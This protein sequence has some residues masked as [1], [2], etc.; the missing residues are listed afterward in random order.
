[1]INYSRVEQGHHSSPPS[2]Q[3]D[4][5]SVGEEQEETVV[6]DQV[7]LDVDDLGGDVEQ[8][9]EVQAEKPSADGHVEEAKQL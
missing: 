6:A 8:A 5:R 2:Q 1:M 3:V 7:E 9:Q 4:E